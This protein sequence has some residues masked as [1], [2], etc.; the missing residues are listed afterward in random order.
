MQSILSCL[1]LVPFHMLHALLCIPSNTQLCVYHYVFVKL[2][3][4]LHL[5]ISRLFLFLL[6]S[7][8][9]RHHEDKIN[10]KATSCNF[11]IKNKIMKT[12]LGGHGRSRWRTEINKEMRMHE[13][14][15]ELK[16][17]WHFAVKILIYGQFLI[18]SL[19]FLISTSSSL[20]NHR[21]YKK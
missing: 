12:R 8:H 1:S 16:W 15:M 19:F 18:S 20:L 9:W 17:G 10:C 6:T 14:E 11:K 3:W 4:S 7:S 13:M 5:M 21:Q 2:S